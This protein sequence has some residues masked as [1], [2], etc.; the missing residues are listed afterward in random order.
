MI[1][2][3][4]LI[5]VLFLL[6]AGFMHAQYI[7][8]FHFKVESAI[9][10]ETREVWVSLPKYYHENSYRCHTLYLLDGDSH[11]SSQ[12]IRAIRNELFERGGYIRPLIIVGIEQKRRSHELSPY[13][14]TGKKFL[15]FIELELVPSI[16]SSFNTNEDRIIAG[17]SMGGYFSLNVW[18]NSEQFNSCFAFSPAIY[19]QENKITKDLEAYLRLQKPKGVV[20]VNN[21]TEGTTENLIQEYIDELKDAF[22]QYGTA[23]LFFQYKEYEGYGHN[24]TP[25]VGM[26]DALL[27]HFSK[28]SFGEELIAKLWDKKVEPI[29]TYENWYSTLDD[30]AGF[31]VKRE[32]DL[33][34]NLAYHYY[35]SGDTL[36]ALELINYALAI[37]STDGF[38]YLGKGEILMGKDKEASKEA[39]IKAL[40]YLK[41]EDVFENTKNFRELEFWKSVVEENLNKLKE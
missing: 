21:G 39:F 8:E 38:S 33:L 23:H 3:N 19:N 37:D 26:T 16:D 15:D 20:Y 14:E 30:W 13:G 36:K 9:L 2:K 17:H 35:N 7:E 6:A 41:P 11:Q 40:I 12:T 31:E 27:F 1:K 34:N 18:M 22:A 28:W 5:T 10:G 25:I 29:T 24:F 4:P 32:N